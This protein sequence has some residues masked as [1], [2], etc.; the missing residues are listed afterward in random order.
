MGEHSTKQAAGVQKIETLGG[1]AQR[2]PVTDLVC[3]AV[4][5]RRASPAHDRACVPR[6]RHHST[7]VSS[8]H[9]RP[10]DHAA[11]LNREAPSGGW[12]KALYHLPNFYSIHT[13]PFYSIHIPPLYSIHTPPLYSIHIP[14]LYSIHTPPLYSIHIPPFYSIQRWSGAPGLSPDRSGDAD[15]PRRGCEMSAGWGSLDG[16]L[17]PADMAIQRQHGH[18]TPIKLG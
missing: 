9:R 7:Y 2:L 18:S 13:P 10:D 8:R 15:K 11:R 6:V 4:E 1:R 14:P 17:R 16:G 5:P 3:V 12:A